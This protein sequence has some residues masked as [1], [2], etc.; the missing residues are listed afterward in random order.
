MAE[1]STK[2]EV[3]QR[4]SEIE[5]L[6]L[7]G[8]T[9]TY[10]LQYASKWDVSDRTVDE[11]TATAKDRVKEVSKL[12]LQDNLGMVLSN[13]W[14]LYRVARA[15]GDVKNS[16]AALGSIAKITGLEQ[17]TVNLIVE[18]K[19]DLETLGNDELNNALEE[20]MKGIQ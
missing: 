14:D 13:Y 3:N 19:R 20:A 11:Y 6:I 18:D 7:E 9:R 10:I 1:K 15:S 4:V 12:S 5:V 17:S 2:A 8:R 16:L